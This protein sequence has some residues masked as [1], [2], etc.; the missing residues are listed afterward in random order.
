MVAQPLGKT[1][2]AARAPNYLCHTN[3]RL[4]NGPEDFSEGK[5]FWMGPF[6]HK[7][8]LAV[9]AP[10]LPPAQHLK[11]LSRLALA[12]MPN[13]CQACHLIYGKGFHDAGDWQ[14]HLIGL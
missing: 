3:H 14:G 5:A 11:T 8:Y 2:L 13:R 12:E 7:A 6:S 10:A 1:T 4:P 9:V